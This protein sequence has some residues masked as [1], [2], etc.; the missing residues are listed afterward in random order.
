MNELFSTSGLLSRGHTDWKIPYTTL[1]S[2]LRDTNSERQEWDTSCQP[3]RLSSTTLDLEHATN[4][5]A[6]GE[7]NLP[8]SQDRQGS[9]FQNHFHIQV[10][11][12]KQS[13]EQSLWHTKSSRSFVFSPPE[14]NS[15]GN[16]HWTV[17]TPEFQSHRKGGAAAHSSSFFLPVLSLNKYTICSYEEAEHQNVT[18]LPIANPCICPIFRNMPMAKDLLPPALLCRINANIPP[19]I[20]S[21]VNL[22]MLFSNAFVKF[23]K[24]SIVISI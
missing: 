9:N 17:L 20:I 10:S 16:T 4:W 21:W 24:F 19:T 22:H 6:T 15:P 11:Q 14:T 3:E 23:S 7:D 12:E 2:M 1:I 13:W 8:I 5:E 18:A